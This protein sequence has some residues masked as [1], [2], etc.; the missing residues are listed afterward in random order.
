MNN[1]N[2]ENKLFLLMSILQKMKIRSNKLLNKGYDNF[3]VLY[4]EGTKRVCVF[5]K[6]VK[7]SV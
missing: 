5:V 2:L 6:I 7:M 4:N 1:L 3:K